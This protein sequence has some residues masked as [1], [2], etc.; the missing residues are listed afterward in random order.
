M[1]PA[2]MAPVWVLVLVVT[3]VV[4]LAGLARAAVLAGWHQEVAG[5]SSPRGRVGAARSGLAI[6]AVRARVRRRWEARA[7]LRRRRIAAGLPEV[8]DDVARALRAGSSLRQ[9]IAAAGAPTRGPA[10]ELM[11]ALA[12]RV[13]MGIPLVVALDQLARDEPGGEV[14]LVVAALRVAAE[15][16]GRAAAAVEAVAATLRERHAAAQEVA[17]HS[18]QAQLSAVVIALLPVAFTVW[19]VATDDRAAAFLLASRAG[20]LCLVGGLGLLGTGA[21]WMARIVGSSR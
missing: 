7:G 14:R 1:T 3:G 10:A 19:C 6:A 20:W 2:I 21:W 15:A 9:A 17:A 8:L 12:A 18:V 16:G 13:E 4:A 11:A 5:R